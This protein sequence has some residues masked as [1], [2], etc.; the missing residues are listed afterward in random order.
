MRT[1]ERREISLDEAEGTS[2][3]DLLL[4]MSKASWFHSF[5]E[6]MEYATRGYQLASELN[7]REGMADAMNRIGNVHYLLIIMTRYLK[8]T[9][10]L[11]KLPQNSMITG[12]WGFT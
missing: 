12:E 1:T 8:T 4:E 3:V 10:R 2:R 9:K 5:D 11:S 6:S 7:Y